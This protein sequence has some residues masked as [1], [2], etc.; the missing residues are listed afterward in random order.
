MGRSLN[1][2]ATDNGVDTRR[3]PH[4]PAQGTTAHSRVTMPQTFRKLH[5]SMCTW[6]VKLRCD[7]QPYWREA[8][9]Q[10]ALYVRLNTKADTS[11]HC[12]VS[13]PT[14]EVSDTEKI[15]RTRSPVG[16]PFCRGRRQ[17][18]FWSATSSGEAVYLSTCG[19]V[20]EKSRLEGT[21][22]A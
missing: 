4:L 11:P 8:A 7:V 12:C 6:Y 15:S 22:A 9:R 1:F 5:H 16:R 18:H 19:R 21:S 13:G 17:P 14:S 10:P 2:I 20:H 3:R